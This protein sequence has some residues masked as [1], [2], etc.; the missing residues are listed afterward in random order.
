M[1]R[2]N[3]ERVL[4]LL[5]GTAL[6]ILGYNQYQKSK[7]ASVALPPPTATPV[8]VGPKL[9]QI[10]EDILAYGHP[11]PVN[12]AIFR[13]GYVGTYSR[14]LRNPIWIAEHLTAASLKQGEGVD[15][16]KSTFQED[17]AVPNKFSAKL[18][19]YFRSGYDRGHM[20]PAADIKITQDALS[21]TFY[22][23][24]I[25]PQVGRG[26]NRD[27][28][29]HL[30]EFCRRLIK[31]EGFTDV[32]VY[33]GPLYLPKDENGKKY[34]KYEV[35]G[36]SG[37]AVPTNFFKVILA[38][39]SEN[40]LAIGAFVLPNESIPDDT[41]L[42]QYVV[43]VEDVERMS[44]L[45]FFDRVDKNAVVP[46]CSATKCVLVPNPKWVQNR[47]KEGRMIK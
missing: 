32:Y 7:P 11:G 9:Q 39:R 20:A 17:P 37:V 12:D 47:N 21:E 19:D 13:S 4:T 10:A 25:A 40:T 35:I 28:W 15:R 18:T 24:N 41:P 43:A 5:G 45:T 31:N 36:A 33:T 23:T 1:L 26:F 30:E 46:L 2:R 22:L 16:S 6:G 34:V 14:Q 44:G 38:K 27:Y 42:E 3:V 8:T 29:A